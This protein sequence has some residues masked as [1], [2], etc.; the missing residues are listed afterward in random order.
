MGWFGSNGSRQ[1]DKRVALVL[2][3]NSIAYVPE[4]QNY[5]PNVSDELKC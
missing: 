5:R 2:A 3:I 1:N 4:D